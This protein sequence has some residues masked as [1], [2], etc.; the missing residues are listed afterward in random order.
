MNLKIKMNF[1]S[2]HQC[3][4]K[5]GCKQ[6]CCKK[7]HPVSNHICSRGWPCQA[8]KGE[9]ALGPLK[10]QCPRVE[11]CQGGKARVGRSVDGWE[12]GRTTH[13]SS[14]SGDGIRGFQ[15]GN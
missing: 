13:R 4:H 2:N 8:S 1:I 15:R 14:G 5:E 7:K 9:E 11:E 12:G 3:Y 10:G 6:V